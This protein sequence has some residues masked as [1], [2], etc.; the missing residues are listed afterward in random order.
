MEEIQTCKTVLLSDKPATDDA[1][2]PH[3]RIAE[4]IATL[5]IEEETGRTIG[6]QGGW[7][8]GKTTVIELLKRRVANTNIAVV[9]FNAW[10]HE[11][12]PLRRT[13]FETIV[14][15]LQDTDGGKGWI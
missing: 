9:D 1:F 10:A 4:A 11:G 3:G 5:I 15:K 8:A 6:L 14:R 7:G 2:K 12:D 13:F